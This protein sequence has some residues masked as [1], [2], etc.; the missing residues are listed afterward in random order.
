MKFIVEAGLSPAAAL[1]TA[2]YNN[3]KILGWEKELGTIEQGKLANM[4]LLEAN[5]L[6]DISNLQKIRAVLLS[7]QYYERS[8]LDSW[9]TDIRQ[10]ALQRKSAAK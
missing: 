3:A 2:T 9:L 8:Q 5:P 7:G 6:D 4:V 1:K 10:L